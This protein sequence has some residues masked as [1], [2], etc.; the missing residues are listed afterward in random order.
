MQI[1]PEYTKLP[2]HILKNDYMNLKEGIRKL[3]EAK[4][5]CKHQADFQWL[6]CYNAGVFG[7]SKV[8]DP[9]QFPYYRKVMGI[10]SK[11]EVWGN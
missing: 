7:G 5:Y 10:Y 1:R 3:A 8:K 6:V 4:K 9:K 11:G 2:T